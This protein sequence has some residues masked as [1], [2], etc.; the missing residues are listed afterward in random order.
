MRVYGQLEFAQFHQSLPASMVTGKGGQFYADITAPAAIIP[1]FWDGTAWRTIFLGGVSA[2]SIVNADIASGAAIAYSKL[3]LTGSILNAD[4]VA[5]AGIPYSK[6]SLGT[7]IVNAD[8]A[9]GAAIA[10]SK[11]AA[12]QVAIGAAQTSDGTVTSTTFADLSNQ[13]TLTFTAAYTGKYKIYV[14]F[15]LSAGTG[16]S[17]IVYRINN[18]VGAA[19]VNFSQEAVQ[20]VATANGQSS[21]AF[22]IAT[23]TAST[24]YTFTLQAKASSGSA[25]CLSSIPTNGVAIIAEQIE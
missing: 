1:K 6:L 14:S 4:I 13:P 5:S 23:L 3:N 2:G 24:A 7:S 25:K 11:I 20:A 8:I 15:P 10:A 21:M 17:V 19:T 22:M 16:G 9:A 18:S 12:R